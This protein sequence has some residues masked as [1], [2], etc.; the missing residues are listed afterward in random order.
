MLRFLSRPVT[1]LGSL[2]IAL[3]L[4]AQMAEGHVCTGCTQERGTVASLAQSEFGQS[5]LCVAD[6]ISF[7][8]RCAPEVKWGIAT[9]ERPSGIETLSL[10]SFQPHQFYR[11][12]IRADPDYLAVKTTDPPLRVRFC[13]FLN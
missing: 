3:L 12:S 10:A 5:D 4:F 1:L 13:R 9:S 8:T 11:A 2:L 7:D 6:A